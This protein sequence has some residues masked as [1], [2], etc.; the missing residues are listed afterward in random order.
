MNPHCVRCMRKCPS[1][2][3]RRQVCGSDGITYPSACHLKGM[4]CRRGKAIPIA[5]KGK[6]KCK[7]IILANFALDRFKTVPFVAVSTTC[8]NFSCKNDELC[9][10]DFETGL[11]R[12]VTCNRKCPKLNHTTGQIC[13]T[14]NKTYR[15]WCFMLRDSCNKG[16][17]IETK[18]AGEC[19]SI[20]NIFG[21]TSTGRALN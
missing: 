14:N 20:S 19:V 2:P 21:I 9:L 17:V 13:G 10:D 16:Y 12:C 1:N 8:N 6:C 7:L 11:S 15:S 4:A 18:Y 5:Y 3:S